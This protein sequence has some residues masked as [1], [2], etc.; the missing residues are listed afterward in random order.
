MGETYTDITLKNA[1]DVENAQRR[2][3]KA[4]AIRKVTVE[5][6]ADTGAITLIINERMR[7]KLGL[8]VRELREVTFANNTKEIAKLAGPVEVHWENRSTVCEAIVVSG[9]GIV[10]LGVIPLESM[11]LMVDPVGERLVG[12]HGDK[13]MGMVR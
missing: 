8:R 1:V 12:K 6:L 13:A 5:A 10:L 3:I 7:R 11:D 4:A 9:D 2:L